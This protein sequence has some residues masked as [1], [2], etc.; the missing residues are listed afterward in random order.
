MNSVDL[1]QRCSRLNQTNLPGEDH[2]CLSVVC[3][4]RELRSVG[5]QH[6]QTQL[7][8]GFDAMEE[9]AVDHADGAVEGQDTEEE[10]EEP[11]EG[12]G[13]QR[14]Q[15]RN[16]FSQFRQTLPDQLLEHR[17]VHLSACRREEWSVLSHDHY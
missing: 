12:D 13:R 8:D 11:R 17:L 9:E 6:C 10:G 4:G 15:V 1:F 2:K 14:G 5:L 16:V 3:A 7:K